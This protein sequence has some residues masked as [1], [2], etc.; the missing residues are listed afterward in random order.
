MKSKINRLQKSSILKNIGIIIKCLKGQPPILIYQMGKVGSK[1][2]ISSLAKADINRR[3]YHVHFLDPNL[4]QEYEIK[5]RNFLGTDRE[6]ALK[7]ICQYSYLRDRIKKR[8][9]DKR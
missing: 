3:I 1:T 7:H 9:K 4:V 2:V 5:R 6:G 8:Q